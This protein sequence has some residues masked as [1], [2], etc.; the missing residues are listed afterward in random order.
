MD[1]KEP[2]RTNIEKV[3]SLAIVSAKKNN[4]TSSSIDISPYRMSQLEV[5]KICSELECTFNVNTEVKTDN[6]TYT[7]NIALNPTLVTPFMA[8]YQRSR[9]DFDDNYEAILE[10]Y[11]P[12]SIKKR[13]GN[14]FLNKPPSVGE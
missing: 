10:T 12:K 4:E 7:I 8:Q 1:N 11:S 3:L 5:L 13:L 2:F 6:D 9:A 14:R